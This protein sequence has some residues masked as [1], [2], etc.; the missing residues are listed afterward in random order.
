M[1]RNRS[2]CES[3]KARRSLTECKEIRHFRVERQ[4]LEKPPEG[5]FLRLNPLK[6]LVAGE[7]LEPPT[8]GL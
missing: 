4:G 1:G 3:L 2:L 5:G 6:D 8:L 7:G